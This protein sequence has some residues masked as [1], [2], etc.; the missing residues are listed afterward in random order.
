MELLRNC[1]I[2]VKV[3]MFWRWMVGDAHRIACT[4]L[5]Y[6]MELYQLTMMTMENAVLGRVHHYQRDGWG[7]KVLVEVLRFTQKGFVVRV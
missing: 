1:T 6:L 3:G 7:G 2:S 5:T 4:N